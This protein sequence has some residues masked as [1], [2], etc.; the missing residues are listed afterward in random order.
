MIPKDIALAV[1]ACCLAMGAWWLQNQYSEIQRTQY[2]LNDRVTREEL[3]YAV[4]GL[5]GRLERIED[6]I[7][8]G[9]SN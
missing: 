3:R 6:L 8:E 4:D 9:Q 7:R 1:F 2:E 5:T